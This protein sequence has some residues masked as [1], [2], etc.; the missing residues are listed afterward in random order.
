MAVERS[1]TTLSHVDDAGPGAVARQETVLIYAREEDRRAEL[2]DVVLSSGW[3]PLIANDSAA[4]MRPLK[5][6]LK[7][8]WI[9]E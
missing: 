5:S 1:P 8:H 4:A 6:T 9:G 3:W 2:V 7:S